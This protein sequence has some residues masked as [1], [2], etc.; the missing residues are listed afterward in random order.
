MIRKIVACLFSIAMLSLTSIVIFGQSDGDVT[1]PVINAENISRLQPVMTIDFADLPDDLVPF[2]A[3]EFDSGAFAT[4]SDASLFA[5]VSNRNEVLLLDQSGEVAGLVWTVNYD[6]LDIA[7]DATDEHFFVLAYNRGQIILTKDRVDLSRGIQRNFEIDGFPQ[8]IWSNDNDE[9]FVE[10]SDA[11]TFIAQLDLDAETYESLPYAPEQ[12]REAVVRI[13]RIPAPYVVTSS[14]DGEIKLWNLETS[15]VE[16]TAQ[17]DNGPAVFG[18]L[19]ADASH[20]AWRDPM[21]QALYV[22]DFATGNNQFVAELNGDYVQYFFLTEDADIVI[23]AHIEDRPEVI[24][25]NVE[26]GEQYQLGQHREC[27]RVPDLIW[28]S[29]DGTTLVVGCDSGLQLWRIVE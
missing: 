18:Q 12:D 24:A 23:A 7:F 20:L 2:G 22:L 29:E 26:T 4:T 8:R 25:W 11:Q 27:G 10:I 1:Y 28:L 3:V 21:S 16:A 19:N 13:G 17:V 15:V 14:N 6:L 5:V 9:V